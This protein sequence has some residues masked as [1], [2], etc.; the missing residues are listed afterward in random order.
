VQIVRDARPLF[1]RGEFLRLLVKLGVADSNRDAVGERLEAVGMLPVEE[2]LLEADEV[3]ETDHVLV[4]R[5]RRA[6]V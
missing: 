1:R 6:E 5:D 3:E 4:K 2:A